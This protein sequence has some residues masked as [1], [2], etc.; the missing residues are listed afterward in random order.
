MQF[1][2][3]SILTGEIGR[4]AAL[5]VAVVYGGLKFR[6]ISALLS[7]IVGAIGTA[8]TIGAVVIGALVLGMATGWVSIDLGQMLS[9]L[10]T[11][12]TALWDTAGKHVFEWVSKEVI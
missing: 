7:G 2:W 1:E 10:W 9:D 5:V 6:R 4:S 3:F 12:G 8:A 11:G